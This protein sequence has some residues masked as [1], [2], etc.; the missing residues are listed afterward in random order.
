MVLLK[1]FALDLKHEVRRLQE[2]TPGSQDKESRLW[3]VT[4]YFE[5]KEFYFLKL[6]R[7]N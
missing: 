6:V 7:S 5:D 4:P 3:E 2:F 1:G